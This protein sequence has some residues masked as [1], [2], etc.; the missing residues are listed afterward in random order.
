MKHPV[1]ATHSG[2]GAQLHIAS[3]ASGEI[4]SDIA[5]QKSFEGTGTALF[6]RGALA[7]LFA[8][9]VIV[10]SSVTVL[11]LV[12]L[13]GLYA[14]VDGVANIVH[15][16]FDRPTGPPGHWSEESPRPSTP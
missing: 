7:I 6:V 4:M 3:R 11:P 14:V 13:F 10:W 1:V 2:K 5:E 8:I 12:F 15:Y 9:L 16:F